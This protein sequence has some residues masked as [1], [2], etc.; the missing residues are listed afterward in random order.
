MAK[1]GARKGARKVGAKTSKKKVQPRTKRSLRPRLYGLLVL[2][3]LFLVL[4]W[5]LEPAQ[6]WLRQR[7]EISLLN[8]RITQLKKENSKLEEEKAKLN[9][10]EYVEQVARKE[11]GLIK[12]G[13]EAYVVIPPSRQP[14]AASDKKPAAEKKDSGIWQKIRNYL[15]KL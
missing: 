10:D 13:E 7:K 11:L 2:A 9:T 12:Q 5:C 8:Q 6:Q 1:K 14:T 15:N 3:L 4:L